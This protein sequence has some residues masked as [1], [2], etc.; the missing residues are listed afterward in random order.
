MN[1]ESF[2]SFG[3]VS[4][5]PRLFTMSGVLTQPSRVRNVSSFMVGVE[6]NAKAS[7]HAIHII[8]LSVPTTVPH[9]PTAGWVQRVAIKGLRAELRLSAHDFTV[10]RSFCSSGSGKL[11]GFGHL[12]LAALH[13]PVRRERVDAEGFDEEHHVVR[14]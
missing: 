5:S 6:P 4:A 10:R 13:E 1:W 8:R 2:G 12:E 3:A 14:L 7:S 9:A 11:L